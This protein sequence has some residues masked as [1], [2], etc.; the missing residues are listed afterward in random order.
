MKFTPIFLVGLTLVSL[1]GPA[2]G[3]TTPTRQS[4]AHPAKGMPRP[5]RVAT[6]THTGSALAIKMDT[7]AFR[8]SGRPADRVPLRKAR[9]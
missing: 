9:K 4:K 6:P 8:R 2:F 7:A 1:C 3:Q 5:Q